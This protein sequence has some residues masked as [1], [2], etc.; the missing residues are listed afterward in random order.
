MEFL[1]YL[2]LAPLENCMRVVLEQAH[3][4][5]GSW[6]FSLILLSGAVNIALIPV[7]HL[8][9]TWQEAE[10]AAQS[11][12]AGKLDELRAAYRGR[13]RYM[14]I[15]TLYRQHGYTPLL[16]LRTSAGLFIQ[17]PFFFAAFH[18][19]NHAPELAGVSFAGVH[20]LSRP[21]GLFVL[22]GFSLNLLPVVMTCANVLSSAVY[23]SR[24]SRRERIQLWL[25]AAIFLVL[26]YTSSAALLIY[27]TC[28]NIFSIVKNLVYQRYLYARMPQGNAHSGASFSSSSPYVPPISSPSGNDQAAPGICLSVSERG[29]AAPASASGDKP[30]GILPPAW[31]DL[32]L[33]LASIGTFITVE[34]LAKSLGRS[35]F[36]ILATTGASAVCAAAALLLRSCRMR[37]FRFGQE[38]YLPPLFMLMAFVA[39]L[40]IW[41]LTSFK[42][43]ESTSAWAQARLYAVAIGCASAWLLSHW[44]VTRPLA[45][46]LE[47][48]R[49]TL[50]EKS[51]GPL[52]CSGVMLA[53][54]IAFWHTPAKIY[55]SDPDFFYEP[56]SKL[57]A[58]TILR[59]LIFCLGAA[60]FFRLSPRPLRPL[61]S[62]VALWLGLGVFVYTFVAAGDYG[63]L[64]GFIF[65]EPALLRSRLSLL[66]DP[67]VM[68]GLAVGIWLCLRLGKGN[69]LSGFLQGACLAL[70]GLGA[71]QLWTA[72]AAATESPGAIQTAD[73]LPE[74]TS[75]LFG[76]SRTEK[77]VV[78]VML[79]MFTGGHVRQI[80][81]EEPELKR[82]LDGFVWYP[83]TMST[84]AATLLS[85]ASI[86]GGEPYSPP[87]INARQPHSLRMELQKGFATLPNV[88]IPRGYDVAFAD[89]DELVPS[90]FSL[91]C[92]R[93]TDMLLVGKSFVSAY[94][95]LWRKRMG[96]P[97]PMPESQAPFL[98]SVGLFYASPWFLRQFIYY[99]GSW[100]NTQTVIHNPSEG[101]M[102]MLHLLPEISGADRSTPTLKYIASQAVHY[103]WRL[104]R[105]TCMPVD[106][107]AQTRQA[108]GAIVQHL[109]TER[110]AL[111]AI[112]R[113]VNWMQSAGVYDNTQI[114]LASDHDG[115]DNALGREYGD[116]RKN[117]VPWKPHALLM[118]KAMGARGALRIDPTLMSTADVVSLICRENGP[119]P[120][121]PGL[122]PTV[123]PAS[124]QRIRTHSAGLASIRRHRDDGFIVNT[125][126]VNGTMFQRGN[127][128]EMKE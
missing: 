126:R 36:A 114:I 2:C 63:T 58:G 74:Y 97:S 121:I 81:D 67:L 55:A 47:F 23:T 123:D 52:F 110:C 19:L 95:P 122:E 89:V 94:T 15:K 118:V 54:V 72:P 3:A 48:C 18:L 111:R 66:V 88:F 44:P 14:F 24:L 4:L 79:D 25:L 34:L 71:Y 42:K 37:S 60:L 68:L 99:E 103:P 27:W 10:R 11:A 106:V 125:Y 1:Y 117:G 16:A 7:Y 101:P 17:I 31:L 49:R 51:V 100:M 26:L 109:D 83:D 40:A 13:E 6:G 75:R 62:A 119:C 128:S 50:A 57:L 77:N 33:G 105:Q 59:G 104:D 98:A 113:W 41:H 84:G 53:A 20:D 86:L 82:Q 85:I 8:A 43:L 64:D 102:A 115:N 73:K 93:V 5:T 80:L 38:R 112:A 61:L 107:T 65:Q 39:T 120:D 29:L 70:V 87:A 22:G 30:Q 78:V 91:V 28:N 124:G 90:E 21:D 127:W 45:R 92:P 76:F 116:M 32:C 9:E 69:M 108:D 35:S 56:L 96:L 12:M 46:A